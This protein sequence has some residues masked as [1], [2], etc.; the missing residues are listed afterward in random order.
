METL[1]KWQ[2]KKIIKIITGIRRCG[3]STLLKQFQ[4]YLQDSGIPL[5]QCIAINFESMASEPLM[6]Y[7]ALYDYVTS[8]LKKKKMNYLF[9]DEIQLVPQFQKVINSLFL[10]DNVDIYLTGSNAHLLSGELATLLSGRYVEIKMQPFTFKEF[11]T[12]LKGNPQNDFSLYCKKGGFPYVLSLTDEEQENQYLSSIYDSIILKDVAARKSTI[13]LPLIN[14]L[15]RFLADNIGNFVSN[16][17]I[18]DFLTSD[19]R[20]TTSVTI[21]SYVEALKN[22]FTIYEAKRYDI[23]GKQILCSLEKFYL[24]DIGLRTFLLGS[25]TKDFGRI[26]ENIVYMELLHR[27]YNVTIGKLREKKIDFIAEKK[28]NK[29]YYQVAASVL[30]PRTFQREIAPLK[31]ITDNFPKYIISQDKEML[32]DNGI[33]QKNIVDFLLE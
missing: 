15:T 7:H 20:K 19:G 11:H 9:F 29:I 1:K 8:K 33:T 17:K 6:E 14:T 23:K 25:Y 2:D 21:A 10:L 12:Y 5:K 32:G 3:K 13:D 22:A 4:E 28:G 18:A 27:G 24:A 26:L 30:D 16:K 31:S